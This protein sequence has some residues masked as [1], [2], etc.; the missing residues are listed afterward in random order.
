MCASSSLS[1]SP[2]VIACHYASP[3]GLEALKPY[4]PQIWP[5]LYGHFESAEEGTRNVVAECVGKLTLLDPDTLLPKLK[6]RGEG[7]GGRGQ[8]AVCM[9]YS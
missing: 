9:G 6:V 3:E 4:V 7:R 8:V 5:V 1:F 2:K